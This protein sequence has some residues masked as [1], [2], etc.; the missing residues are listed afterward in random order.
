M[1]C[2]VDWLVLDMVAMSNPF[3]KYT[4]QWKTM[5]ITLFC[6]IGMQ[7]KFMLPLVKVADGSSCRLASSGISDSCILTLMETTT[8]MK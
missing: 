6:I 1:P 4:D 3:V 2:P 7:Q 5:A 8:V